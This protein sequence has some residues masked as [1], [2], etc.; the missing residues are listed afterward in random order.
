MATVDGHVRQI[1][2]GSSLAAG[3]YN[4]PV[5]AINYNG[6]DSETIVL[7]VTAPAFSNDKSINFANQDWL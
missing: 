4:I 6:E 5:K 2:G 3:S 7:T 1:I